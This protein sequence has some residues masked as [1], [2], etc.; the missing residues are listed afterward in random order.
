MRSAKSNFAALLVVDG[1]RTV[2]HVERR[3]SCTI[4]DRQVDYGNEV[5]A[6]TWV[7][8]PYTIN[9]LFRLLIVNSHL[10]LQL[11]QQIGVY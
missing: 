11:V 5:G 7:A 9:V 8:F 6:V 4:L 10:L 1:N 3:N 2:K